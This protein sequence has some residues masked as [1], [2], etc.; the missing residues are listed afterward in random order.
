MPPADPAVRAELD[1]EARPER[2]ARDARR[3]GAVDPATAA[4]LAPNDSQ[5]IQRALEVH[6]I[7]GR[8]LSA[9]HT[10]KSIATDDQST[11]GLPLIS[12]EPA[13]R[14]LAARAHRPAFRRHAAGGPAGR[15]PPAARARR[16]ARRSAVHALRGLPPGLGAARCT[17]RR[18][19][20][21]GG[22]G[23]A[24]HQRHAPA[25]QAAD[26]LAA[27]HAGSAIVPCDHPDALAQVLARS[28]NSS[29][30]APAH[31]PRR[32]PPHQAL[33][34]HGR[35]CQRLAERGAR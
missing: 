27:V 29:H 3:A 26:H 1:A 10:P 17:D 9:F 22:T 14:G 24:R 5:R 31:E 8:P 12:L 28:I 16:P 30:T 20:L 25:R 23:C 34:R 15:G 11:P 35:V 4:R 6:R 2:L 7:S 13:D 21:S 18:R 33:R 32:Q 19:A